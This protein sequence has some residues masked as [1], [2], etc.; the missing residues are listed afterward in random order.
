ML[1]KLIVILLYFIQ[2]ILYIDNDKEIIFINHCFNLII[3]EMKKIIT[4]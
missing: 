2:T 1:I 4:M 3:R